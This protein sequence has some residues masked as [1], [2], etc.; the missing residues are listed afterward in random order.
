MRS[1]PTDAKARVDA[2]EAIIL[3]VVSPMAWQQLDRAIQGAVRIAPDELRE[4]WG[5]LPRERAVIAYCT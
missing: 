5:E 2:G 3:D 4:R 1:D